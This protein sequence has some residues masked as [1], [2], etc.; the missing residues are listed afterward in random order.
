[1]S[2]IVRIGNDN[3]M[4]QIK[5]PSSALARALSNPVLADDERLELLADTASWKQVAVRHPLLKSSV[6]TVL[7]P[8][9]FDDAE[10]VEQYLV[11]SK[12]A[13]DNDRQL[14]SRA[15]VLGADHRRYAVAV[16]NIESLWLQHA[17]GTKPAW[18][19]TEDAE[20]QF[21]LSAYFNCPERKFA[22]DVN[23]YEYIEHKDGVGPV[24]LVDNAGI[25]LMFANLMGTP[26]AVVS[27]GALTANTTTPSAT[28]TTLASEITTA[29]GGLLR[30]V[31]TYAHT[32]S[33]TTGTLTHTWTA[34]GSD[35]L[36][37]TIGKWGALNASS[38]GTL[39]ASDLVSPT[40]TLSSSGDSLTLTYTLTL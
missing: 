2:T 12:T 17:N 11:Q 38:A 40:A 10:E 27:Y 39:F 19:S 22:E 29:G 31:M 8:D 16:H 35:S 26:A 32:A 14:A 37:V 24:A 21:A 18:V 33:T 23:E 28:D 15:A 34:N 9:G 30:A 3:P 25:D 7:L 13:G 4:Q 6:T 36:P 1:M 20:L 5:I